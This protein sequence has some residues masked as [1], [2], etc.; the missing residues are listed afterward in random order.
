[1]AL[2]KWQWYTNKG[3]KSKLAYYANTPE[4][5][6]ELYNFIITTYN[7][8]RGGVLKRLFRELFHIKPDI[9]VS[10]ISIPDDREYIRIYYTLK[11]TTDSLIF[12]FQTRYSN[13]INIEFGLGDEEVN[14]NQNEISVKGMFYFMEYTAKFVLDCIKN[15]ELYRI[16]LII[17]KCLENLR[18]ETKNDRELETLLEQRGC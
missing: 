11:D 10:G 18:K 16:D 1:M 12:T 9:R 14:F 5:I 17:D 15:K 2:E 7:K 8:K 4:T 3:D 13:T 6:Q